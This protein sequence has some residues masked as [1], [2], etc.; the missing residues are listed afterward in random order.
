MKVEQESAGF[1]KR[2]FS[3]DSQKGSF[4]FFW[5]S[6]F[7]LSKLLTVEKEDEGD[8]EGDG[9]GDG[10]D[11]EEDGRDNGRKEEEGDE[12]FKGGEGDLISFIFWTFLALLPLMFL[13]WHFLLPF[14]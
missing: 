13:F 12:G 2:F 9:K 7:Q 4:K 6:G 10:G 8:E 11:E 1:A 3:Q 5:K 14:L